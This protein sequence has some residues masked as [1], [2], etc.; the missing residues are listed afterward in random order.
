[1]PRVVVDHKSWQF[2]LI[3]RGTA[4]LYEAKGYQLQSRWIIFFNLIARFT[5]TII[6]KNEAVEPEKDSHPK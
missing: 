2:P 3:L 5:R 6:F 1:M 4:P